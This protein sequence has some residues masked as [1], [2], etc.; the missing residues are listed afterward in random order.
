ME[1]KISIIIAD[2][3][4]IFRKGLK[5]LI[6]EENIFSVEGEAADGEE[7]LKLLF[8]VNPQIAV[9]DLDMPKLNGI[10]VLKKIKESGC[11]AKVIFLTMHNSE[12]YLNKALEYGAKG[13][14]LKDSAMR[15]IINAISKVMQDDYYV[16]PSMTKYLVSMIKGSSTTSEKIKGYNTLTPVEK[17]ILTLI[18]EY[19]TSKEIASEL[20][21]SHRTVEKHRDNISKK[22]NLTG[23]RALL[24]FAVKNRN[25]L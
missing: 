13:Y 10:E 17:R 23:P 12:E 22:L 19:K 4:P 6:Q 15:E 7:T 24:K 18:A 21:I 2:D 8:E 14:V 16:S 11:N 25:Y 20:L 5:E 9:I 3:H 1:T